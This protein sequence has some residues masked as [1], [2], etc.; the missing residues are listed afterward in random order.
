MKL[1]PT[2]L[3]VH[4][5][6]RNPPCPVICRNPMPRERNLSS[7]ARQSRSLE[8]RCTARTCWQAV[9]RSHPKAMQFEE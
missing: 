6:P 5:Q 2:P 3:P 8:L 4:D 7:Q 1:P 9:M